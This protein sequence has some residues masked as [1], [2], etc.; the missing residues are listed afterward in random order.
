MAMESRS[1]QIGEDRKRK[2]TFASRAR[3]LY[4]KA[5]HLFYNCGSNLA[6]IM[7]GTPLRPFCTTDIELFS[8][9][10]L[11]TPEAVKFI[12]QQDV[13]TVCYLPF[14]QRLTSYPASRNVQLLEL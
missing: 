1:A 11:S 7:S 9:S 2:R 6:V 3:T 13:E 10:F 4:L 14:I 5:C 12:T 8:Q